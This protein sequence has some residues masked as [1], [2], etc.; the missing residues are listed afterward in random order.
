MSASAPLL[1]SGAFALTEPS[2]VFPRLTAYQQMR[3]GRVALLPFF[4]PG[5]P[6][7]ATAISDLKGAYGA[8]L[9]SN[10]GPVVASSGL[11]DAVHAIEE[12]EQTAR[13]YLLIGGRPVRLVP[14]SP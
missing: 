13:I 8:I 14:T 5:D 9:L 11:Q 7:V 2:D 6:D 4:Q 3:L 10:H 12:L 1:T